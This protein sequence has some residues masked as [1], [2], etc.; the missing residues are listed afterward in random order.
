MGEIARFTSNARVSKRGYSRST[1]AGLSKAQSKT[2]REWEEAHR[3]DRIESVAVVDA[4][5]N[6]NPLGDPIKRGSQG[7]G[8]VEILTDRIPENAIITHNH[9]SA[10]MT[11]IAGRVGNALGRADVATAIGNN[12]KEMRAASPGYIYSVKRP[13][14]GWGVS[15]SEF[16]KAYDKERRKQMEEYEG[17]LPYGW[18]SS[19]DEVARVNSRFSVTMADNTMKAISKKYGFTYSRRR[20]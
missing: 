6:L 5:G 19:R 18:E 4:D 11:G 20:R 14:S 10:G 2:V 3:N 16:K 8:Q 9:P 7:S 17:K 13:A 12:A 1:E 15:A